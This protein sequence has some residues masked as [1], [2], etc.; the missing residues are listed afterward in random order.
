MKKISYWFPLIFLA[1][2]VMATTES[3]SNKKLSKNKISKIIY[4]YGD[5]SVPPKYHRSY[6]I[7]ATQDQ[8]RIVVDSYGNIL[9]DT[10]YQMTEE[11]FGVLTD[12]LVKSK[13]KN[14]KKVEDNKGCTGGTSKSIQVFEGE[15]IVFEGDAY[16]CGGKVFGDMEGDFDSFAAEI[17]GMIP[18]LSKLLE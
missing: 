7:T 16:F 12:N 14:I 4:S 1:V 6:T 10:T 2:I 13:I 5:S 18:N 11:S 8:I 9:A 15:K 3:C 17:K